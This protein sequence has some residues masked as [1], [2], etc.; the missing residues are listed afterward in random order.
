MH[1][2]QIERSKVFVEG[3]VDQVSVDVEEECV[4]VVL[5]RFDVAYPVQLVLNDGDGS[6]QNGRLA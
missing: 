5:R 6:A 3:E 2:C 1:H 4:L